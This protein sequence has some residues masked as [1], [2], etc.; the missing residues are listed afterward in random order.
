MRKP[1]HT[2]RRPFRDGPRPI[3]N[4][5]VN[6]PS[7]KV[8]PTGAPTA[9]TPADPCCGIG[10]GRTTCVRARRS[11]SGGAREEHTYTPAPGGGA[12]HHHQWSSVRCPVTP[13][14]AAAGHIRHFILLLLLLYI[15]LTL[16]HNIIRPHSLRRAVGERA[17]PK[18][19]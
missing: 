19:E 3:L 16:K 2:R 8:S 14:L 7:R 18:T 15:V 4:L 12:H 5:T 10:R 9:R 1:P 13:P 6:R 17:K 11:G